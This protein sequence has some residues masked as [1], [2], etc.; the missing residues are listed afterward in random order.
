[1]KTYIFIDR[2][3]LHNNKPAICYQQGYDGKERVCR[4]IE[5]DKG[6]VVQ[7]DGD[8][9]IPPWDVKVAVVVEGG[10]RIVK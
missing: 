6:T 4:Q 2:E 3:A 10:V 1:M 5:F 7:A 8:S 9:L